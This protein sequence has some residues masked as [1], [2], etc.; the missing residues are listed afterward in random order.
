M[1]QQQSFQ[2]R[3][4]F[5]ILTRAEWTKNS[6]D[7]W[8]LVSV[9]N[10][11]VDCGCPRMP[12]KL[13]MKVW[14]SYVNLQSELW[15]IDLGHFWTPDPWNVFLKQ[16]RLTVYATPQLAQMTLSPQHCTSLWVSGH[17]HICSMIQHIYA[18]TYVCIYAYVNFSSVFSS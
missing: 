3:K 8:C 10:W 12:Q 14:F 6:I 7:L 1:L 11:R 15:E 17:L 2:D 18:Y 13:K 5:L 16:V 9:H 4:N